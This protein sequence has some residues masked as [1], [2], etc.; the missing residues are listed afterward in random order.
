MKNKITHYLVLLM[1]MNEE[2]RLHEVD[3]CMYVKKG[4]EQAHGMEKADRDRRLT[5]GRIASE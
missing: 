2:E 1:S 3:I 4:T 5:V